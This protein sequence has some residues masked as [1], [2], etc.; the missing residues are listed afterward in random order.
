MK[1]YRRLRRYSRRGL[2]TFAAGLML[3]FFTSAA[4][5]Q[6]LTGTLSG[7]AV[8]A[9]GAAIPNANVTLRNQASGD[10][11]TALT[12]GRGH[13]VITAVQPATY[14]VNISASGF[15]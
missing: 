12:D 7:T 1:I 9:S 2:T 10:V 5:A 13:F 11:R 6:Q 3:F 14:S 4:S 8:D 15:R